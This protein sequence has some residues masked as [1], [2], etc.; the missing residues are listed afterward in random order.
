MATVTSPA[1]SR[2]TTYPGWFFLPAAIIYGVLF[3]APT[4]ASFYFSLTRWTLFNSTFI[5]LDNFAQFFREPFLIK[6]LLNTVIYAVISSG[7][8]VILGLLLAVLLTSQIAARGYLRS[9]VFFPVL[10]STVGVGITFT[11]LMH[12]TQGMINEGLAALGIKGPGWLVD[13]NLALISVALVDVWKGVGLATVIYIAGI[14]AI[15]KDYYEAAR[16]DGSTSFQSFLYVTLPLC[17]PATVTV[18]TLSFIGGLRTFDLIWA[19]TRGGP[20]FSSDTIASV[21]YKQ[22]QAGFYGLSTAGNVVLFV[23][24]AILVVPLTMLLN[25]KEGHE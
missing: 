14:V 21:I 19:M 1:R 7:L 20:G 11:V 22:Y 9:V 13:P 3:L 18:I 23:L 12:P 15:P 6:G 24:I 17:R 16:I 5:G 4:F 25:R 10:V 2:A 8:K